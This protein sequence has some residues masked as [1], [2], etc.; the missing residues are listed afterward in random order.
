M[1]IAMAATIFTWSQIF[2]TVPAQQRGSELDTRLD[3]A[4]HDIQKQLA[5]QRGNIEGFDIDTCRLA[6][7]VHNIISSREGESHKLDGPDDVLFVT[8]E[9]GQ[10][11]K[12]DSTVLEANGP[13]EHKLHEREELAEPVSLPF[14]DELLPGHRYFCDVDDR[15]D[16]IVVAVVEKH[17]EKHVLVKKVVV[18]EG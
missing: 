3:L 10:P 9:P 1:A 11:E 14:C 6:L 5:Q 17:V 8:L 2:N 12:F 16:C 7:A 4:A 18:V 15:E 13:S